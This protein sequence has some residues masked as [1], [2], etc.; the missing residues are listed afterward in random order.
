MTKLPDYH[1][2]TKI[3]IEPPTG[4]GTAFRIRYKS[5]DT[6]D[7]WTILK[8]PEIELANNLLKDGTVSRE[9]THEKLTL[10]LAAQYAHRDRKKK[11]APFMTKNLELVEKMWEEKYNRRR[12]RKMKRP[13]DA[14]YQLVKAAEACG[15][16]PLDTCDLET[17]ADYLDLTLGD[18]QNRLQRRITWINSILQWLGRNK[19]QTVD[20]TRSKVKYLNETEFKQICAY[21]KD[22]TTLTLAKIAFYTGARIGEIFFIQPRHLQGNVLFLELQMTDV[23]LPDG[24]YKEDTL[25]SGYSRDIFLYE[26]VQAELEEWSKVPFADRY[27]IR[28]KSF[29]KAITRACKKAFGETDPIKLLNFHALRHCHAI[30]LLQASATITEVAQQLG[31]SPDV[32]YR[33]YSGFELKKESVERLKSLVAPPK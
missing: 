11:K 21:I 12:L 25:K 32:C 18:N 1:L 5:P 14:K 16:H 22:P 8:L 9:H 29:C 26:G 13:D 28:E 2:E 20:R 7:K 3:R 31:N 23:K 27:K 19:L 4:K 17:L 33:Y 30:W 10:I 15:L 24:T 6:N